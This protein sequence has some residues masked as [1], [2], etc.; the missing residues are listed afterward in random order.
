MSHSRCHS[1]WGKSG[2]VPGLHGR[3]AH[4]RWP[5]GGLGGETDQP[6]GLGPRQHPWMHIERVPLSSHPTPSPPTLPLPPLPQPPLH[7]WQ[8]WA[9]QGLTQL[10]NNSLLPTTHPR[11]PEFCLIPEASSLGG[12]GPGRGSLG[13]LPGHTYSVQSSLSAGDFRRCWL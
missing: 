1:H 11:P 9:P 8:E 10:G 3:R 13:R 4:A 5:W 6:R 7:S 12:D 2:D